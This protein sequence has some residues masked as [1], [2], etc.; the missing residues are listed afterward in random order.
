MHS[1]VKSREQ[2]AILVFVLCSILK[3]QDLWSREVLCRQPSL[4]PRLLPTFR[5]LC[6]QPSLVPRLLPAFRVLCRQPSLVP[7]LLPTFRDGK[8][9]G[10]EAITNLHNH[11]TQENAHIMVAKKL[12]CLCLRHLQQR[13]FLST[14]STGLM[15]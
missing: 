10:Y 13:T 6:H 5:V 4:V 1:F 9:S 3:L 7:R 14:Q 12:L 11:V 8:E 2:V 15:L